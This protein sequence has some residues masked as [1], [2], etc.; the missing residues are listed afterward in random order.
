MDLS[1]PSGP[2]FAGSWVALRKQGRRL[3]ARSR[4]PGPRPS[5]AGSRSR[6]LDW[7]RLDSHPDGRGLARKTGVYREATYVLRNSDAISIKR[8]AIVFGTRI[9]CFVRSQYGKRSKSFVVNGEPVQ[10]RGVA[11]RIVRGRWNIPLPLRPCVRE[12]DRPVCDALHA[13][14]AIER[15]S[16]RA[17][18]RR[19]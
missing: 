3:K 17:C 11:R 7:T 6:L 15:G 8:E 19:L 5:D 9:V 16:A 4:S 2:N 12:G 14:S 13:R 10:R 18:E 1:T